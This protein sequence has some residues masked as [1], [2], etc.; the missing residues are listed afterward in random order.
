MSEKEAF[1]RIITLERKARKE[2]E[3]IMEEKS[4]ELLEANEKLSELNIYLEKE[5][6]DRIISDF[7]F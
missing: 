7:N 5:V 2:A 1:E 4:L 3:R 6:A